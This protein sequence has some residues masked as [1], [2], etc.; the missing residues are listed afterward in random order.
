M[1]VITLGGDDDLRGVQFDLDLSPATT[2]EQLAAVHVFALD[3]VAAA[4][5]ELDLDLVLATMARSIGDAVPMTLPGDGRTF[6]VSS[7]HLDDG[8]VHVFVTV[9]PVGGEL[10]IDQ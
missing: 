7:T 5:P 9:T 3:V 2:E 6:R 1:A 10:P 4:V 8:G